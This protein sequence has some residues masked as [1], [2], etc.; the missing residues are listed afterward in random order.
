MSLIC[1]GQ[2]QGLNSNFCGLWVEVIM[3]DQL[4]V[5][6]LIMWLGIVLANGGV[7]GWL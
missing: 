2:G 1:V 7:V 6:E 3:G 5:R 4:R